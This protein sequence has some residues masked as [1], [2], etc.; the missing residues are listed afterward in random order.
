MVL[1]LHMLL[2]HYC[3]DARDGNKA[4]CV[5][6]NAVVFKVKSTNLKSDSNNF[7]YGTPRPNC[8]HFALHCRAC[9]GGKCHRHNYVDTDCV[10]HFGVCKKICA[11]HVDGYGA[12]FLLSSST[13][14]GAGMLASRIFQAASIF[15]CHE[16]LGGP[17]VPICVG[18]D[19]NVRR[20]LYMLL[21]G[22][23]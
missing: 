8:G 6:V 19:G 17:F 20:C 3:L 13:L 10:V 22:S 2:L 21:N 16:H 11:E 18:G 4:R 15:N 23:F 12:L 1:I 14:H 5:I 7:N 9:F